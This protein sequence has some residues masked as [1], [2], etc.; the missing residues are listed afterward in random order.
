MQKK[1]LVIFN[2]LTIAKEFENMSKVAVH[3]SE[4]DKGVTM[5][6]YLEGKAY[7]VTPEHPCYGQVVKLL[8]TGTEKELKELL[9]VDRAVE[10]FVNQ[11]N[12]G[13][14]ATVKD[15]Q[16]YYDGQVVHNAIA[17][18]IVGLM[19]AGL[20]FANLL[21]FIER[22]KRN[23]SFQSQRE[24]F[25][26]LDRK[27]LPITEDGCFL[28]YKAVRGDFKDIYSGTIDNSP[29]QVVKMSRSLVDD[30]RANHCSKG[31]HVGAMDYVIWYGGR[32]NGNKVVIVKVD[33]EFCVSVPS[34]H[35]FMKLRT[36]QY[37]VLREYDGFLEDALY[38][39]AGVAVPAAY[40]DYDWDG[41]DEDEDDY[42]DSSVVDEEDDYED[43]E[44]DS[45]DVVSSPA[46]GSNCGCSTPVAEDSYLA[47][48]PATSTQAG[49]PYHNKRV[50]GRFAPK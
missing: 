31:L 20:D 50:K 42:E 8:K 24:L 25:D 27:G 4:S 44:F 38:T 1:L 26:F 34:D 35:D 2:S 46:C 47:V 3:Y 7:P 22:V 15:G 13:G 40:D 10:R 14:K 11:A 39:P 18:R 30:D 41:F 36:C 23:P 19:K 43:D 29:G 9:D 17:T 21:R 28:G 6:L 49:R 45:G 48:K 37:E 12:H 33:P 5:T 32:D 16:V